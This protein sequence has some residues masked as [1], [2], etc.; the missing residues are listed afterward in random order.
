MGSLYQR[1]YLLLHCPMMDN[2]KHGKL[3]QQTALGQVPPEWWTRILFSQQF[4]ITFNQQEQLVCLINNLRCRTMF[5]PISFQSF[6]TY[7]TPTNNSYCSVVPFSMQG[8]S[9]CPG[10][11]NRQA[12][13]YITTDKE[14]NFCIQSTLHIPRKASLKSSFPSK[15]L[16]HKL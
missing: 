12:L 9:M 5:S 6:P 7:K 11:S 8:E 16:L 1:P 14:Y 15:I 13:A 3:F 10:R 4:S 2:I